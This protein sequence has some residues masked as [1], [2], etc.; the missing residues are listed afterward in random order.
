MFARSMFLTCS[1]S[2]VV[3]GSRDKTLRVWDI[4][5]GECL[6]T[7]VGHNAAV[8][9]VQYDGKLV[10]SGA[11]D[12]TVRVWNPQLKHCLHTLEGHTNRVHSLQVIHSVNITL[13]FRVLTTT[14]PFKTSLTAFTSCPARWTK[15]S[16]CGM[17]KRASAS[18]RCGEKKVPLSA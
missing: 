9:C 15:R 17:P 16:G 5:E 12:N 7:L 3:S 10:V 8:R 14:V 18:E 6:N 2:R 11:Y 1:V 4:I 13:N